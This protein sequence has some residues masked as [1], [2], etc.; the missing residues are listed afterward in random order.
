MMHKMLKKGKLDSD[1]LVARL[2]LLPTIVI[3]LIFVYGFILFTIYISFTNSKILPNND[4]VGIRNYINLFK[5]NHWMV[6]LKNMG[7]FFVLYIGISTLIGLVLAIVIDL[8]RLGESIF[9]PIFIYPMAISFIVT[10][11]AW[12]WFLDPGIGLEHVMRLWGFTDFVFDWIKN[13]EKSIYTIVIAAIW[14]VSG[15]VMIN[16]LAGIRAIEHST[17]ESAVVDGAGY[18]GF[19]PESS[20]R[21]LAHPF[22]RSLSYWGTWLL[23]HTIWWLP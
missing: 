16:F 22:F 20:Y 1:D 23:N 4:W 3:S 14:Q 7:I 17:I 11:T 8:N 5:L 15:F 2:T 13:S 21:S 12:K 18:S 6:A 10:G 9:R 19:I